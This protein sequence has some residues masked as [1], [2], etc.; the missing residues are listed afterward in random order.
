MTKAEKKHVEDMH[1][2]ILNLYSW[3]GMKPP[4]SWN[5]EE[6]SLIIY[7]AIREIGRKEMSKVPT[8]Y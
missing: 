4:E 3:C 8:L 7:N 2:F 1:L 5:P 6:E